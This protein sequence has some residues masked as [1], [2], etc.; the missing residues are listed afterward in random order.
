MGGRRFANVDFCMLSGTKRHRCLRCHYHNYDVNCQYCIYFWERMKE[1]AELQRQHPELNVVGEAVWPK[2]VVGIGKMHVNMHKE[3][4]KY[5]HSMN[6]LP[7]AA[8]TD[9]EA[10]ERWWAPMNL[11]RQSTRE[12]NWGH[13]HDTLNAWC[14][15]KN[16][17]STNRLRE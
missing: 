5:L 13:R 16:F 3:D 17:S 7:G 12:M 1:F 4:C 9:G 11:V 10:D 2:M 8:E 6:Y 14:D 15:D